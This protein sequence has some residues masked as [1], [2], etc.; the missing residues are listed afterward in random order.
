MN[1]KMIA[2]RYG[3]R[4]TT[5]SFEA[6]AELLSASFDPKAQRGSREIRKNQECA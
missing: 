4:P 2:E 6:G 3:H 1:M 5:I